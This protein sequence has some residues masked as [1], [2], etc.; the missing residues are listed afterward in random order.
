MKVRIPVPGYF[1][2]PWLS[3]RLM[4]HGVSLSRVKWTNAISTG[5]ILA[6]A[7][8]APLQGATLDLYD[9]APRFRSASDSCILAIA[10]LA[11]VALAIFA[12][13]VMA[14]VSDRRILKGSKR[15]KATEESYR[16]LF[17]RSP[18]GIYQ[19]TTDGKI[20]DA[21]EACARLWG[22]AS[23]VEARSG[24]IQQ[25]FAD[26]EAYTEFM[27]ILEAE[28]RVSGREIRFVRRDGKTA[29][30][31]LN[32][33][34]IE[35]EA[36]GSVVIQATMM[37]ITEQ[38]ELEMIAVQRDTAEAASLAKSE[39]LAR[40]SHEIRT[41]MN[42]I[43]GMTEIV[44]DT[45]LDAEQREYL[46]CVKTSARSL[47]A[48]INDV[49]D[50]SKIEANR[51]ELDP[52]EFKLQLELRDAMKTLAVG[53]HEK[54][55][56]FTCDIAPGFPEIVLGDP[57]RLRQIL[58]NL[59]ANAIKFTE[60][61]S[62]VL[63][64]SSTTRDDEA[65]L[66]FEVIDTGIGI[67]KDKQK[68]I[69]DPF[70]Q[71]DSSIARQFGGTG[72]GLT[73]SAW[74]AERMG[75]SIWLESAPGHGST[76]HFSVTLP[77]PRPSSPDL[78]ALSAALMLAGK[79]VM[80]IEDNPETGCVL[81]ELL[82]RCQM[83]PV[84]VSSGQ[85]AMT[86]LVEPVASRQHIDLLLIDAQLS[87]ADGFEIVHRLRRKSSVEIPVVMMLDSVSR[88]HDL[89]RCRSL[90]IEAYVMKPVW[91]MDLEKAM[92]A[93][94]QNQNLSGSSNLQSASAILPATDRP[95]SILLAEDNLINQKV[96]SRLL[97][98]Q[99]HQVHIANNGVEA[100]NAMLSESFDAVFMDIQMPEMSGLEAT[101]RLREQE[102]SDGRRQLIIAMTAHALAGDREKCLQAGMDEY[103]SKP[104]NVNE[105][106][107]LLGKVDVDRRISA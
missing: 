53:A 107:A 89:A 40:M 44:L 3:L 88:V 45:N 59:V 39:F 81:E 15:R 69:F 5:L 71:V 34:L 78:Y 63:R 46:G 4:M 87:G 98:K 11:L 97:E 61:G 77:L 99:G 67:P 43:I 28:Q 79:T 56:E 7:H 47:L 33:F 80:V 10:A 26:A 60:Q 94:L 103:I 55:L 84:L 8:Q 21:N 75:G 31:L 102:K 73:I 14:A 22:C 100:L 70:S 85:D 91:K 25:Y 35:G 18:A 36:A 58:V 50:F 23:R 16:L 32:A 76:F 30:A 17:E 48:I 13:A 49:L 12:T 27:L 20:L 106:Y 2:S 41:P 57:T 19:A 92:R 51:I 68:M 93:A 65:D 96:A 54:R 74:L 62:V 6:A 29:W 101:R 24:S 90:G 105:L 52:V 82:R 9:A 86:L 38:K 104:F 72:L 64:A 1:A 42:G 37:D 66:H 83:N 95:L